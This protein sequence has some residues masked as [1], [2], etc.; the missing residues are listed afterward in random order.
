MRLNLEQR[1]QS[2]AID[3]R[4]PNVL[5]AGVGGFGT[6]TLYKSIDGAESWVDLEQGNHALFDGVVSLA[7]DP[8]NTNI[9]YAGTDMNGRLLKSTD[10]G[11]TWN[12]TGLGA[13][14]RVIDLVA[15]FPHANNIIYAGVRF[16]GFFH[17]I[18]GGASWSRLESNFPDTTFST[19][20]LLFDPTDSQ[21]MYVTILREVHKSVNS[22]K[23]WAKLS[24][25]AQKN[26]LQVLEI[27]LSGSSVYGTSLQNGIH[28]FRVR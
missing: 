5:Y 21:I 7:I 28:V 4:N 17:S 23:S 24:N 14:A 12:E 26:T 15:I 3:P 25:D 9:V 11:Q 27:D 20:A 8:S 6:G 22:G 13:T 18:D 1:V 16:K 19:R 2:L 10:G